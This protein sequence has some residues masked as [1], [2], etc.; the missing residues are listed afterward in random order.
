MDVV[1][2][3]S[4]VTLRK[5]T[6]NWVNRGPWVA[7]TGYRRFV[8]FKKLTFIIQTL[9][10]YPSVQNGQGLDL[11]CGEGNI[12]L[13]LSSLGYRLIGIDIA[14]GDI[15]TAKD[16]KA[17][18]LGSQD[19]PEFLVGDVESLPISEGA[20]DFVICSEVLEHLKHPEKA[21]DSTFRVLKKRG[22]LIVTVPNGFGPYSLIYD[23]FRNK[24]V[25]KITSNIGRSEHLN[26][27]TLGRIKSLLNQAG[28]RNFVRVK[29]SEF[30]SFLPI[31]VKSE[32][33][34]RWDCKLADNLPPIMV[35]GFYIVCRKE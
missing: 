16:R 12:S 13:P 33:F 3:K 8:D 29:N 22:I 20:F 27:F 32:M 34:C 15:S 4:V 24:V 7:Y 19:S 9:N 6:R 2:N 5:G 30:V 11:G 18:L 21:L 10:E 17:R 35:S 26:V 25:S 31:L 28:F 1:N 23:H 14:T